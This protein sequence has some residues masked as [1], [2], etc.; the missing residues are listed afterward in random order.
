MIAV[1]LGAPIATHNV[2]RKLADA[3][4]ARVTGDLFDQ[5]QSKWIVV[6]YLAKVVPSGSLDALGVSRTLC[7]KVEFILFGVQL[8]L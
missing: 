2:H 6:E 1:I 3:V 4:S 7:S 8:K 5:L